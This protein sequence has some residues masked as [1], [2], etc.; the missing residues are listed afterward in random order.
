MATFEAQVMTKLSNSEVELKKSVAY[1][2][3]VYTD[4][5]MPDTVLYNDRYN[6]SVIEIV[7]C[8]SITCNLYIKTCLR[9]TFIA[10]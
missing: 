7:K 9:F 3:S 2:K 4:T 8:Q 6:L 1:K 5:V 10:E